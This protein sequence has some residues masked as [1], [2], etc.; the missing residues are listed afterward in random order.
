M[1]GSA[2]PV[3]TA[4]R[5]RTSIFEL[6]RFA[7]V[8]FGLNL[9]LYLV[10]L[11]LLWMGM[12]YRLAMTATYVAGMLLGHTLHSRYTFRVRQD[13]RTFL[14]YIAA[15]VVGYLMNLTGLMTL[16]DAIGLSEAIAQ[17]TM[18]FV[19]AAFLFVVQRAWVFSTQSTE[20]V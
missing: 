9:A 1:K 4:S 18:I 16:V 7:V 17:A 2:I 15:Y 8:G 6:G 19:V 13:G 5:L 11:S 10:Y 12:E 3:D 14:R 20:A